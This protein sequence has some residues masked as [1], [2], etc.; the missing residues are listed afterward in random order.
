[1]VN[2]DTTTTERPLRR[3]TPRMMATVAS[4]RARYKYEFEDGL[5]RRSGGSFPWP[6]RLKDLLREVFWARD[7]AMAEWGDSDSWDALLSAV[8]EEWA[9]LV[10]DRAPANIDR[11][12][13]DTSITSTALEARAIANH[14]Q[15]VHHGGFS[16]PQIWRDKHGPVVRRMVEFKPPIP[17]DRD[18]SYRVRS[19][20]SLAITLD[21]VVS[22]HGVPWLVVRHFTSDRDRES[23]LADLKQRMD[24][25]GHAWGAA[26]AIGCGVA[27]ILFDVI[28]TKPPSRPGTVQCRHCKG[29]GESVDPVTTAKAEC[30]QCAGTGVGGLSKQACDTTTE[31][32]KDTLMRYPHLLT[33]E[34]AA[35]HRDAVLRLRERGETFAYR[36]LVKVPREALVEW[37]FDTYATIKEL[38]A[39]RRHGR[40]PRN[41]AA[42]L[43]RAG[44]CPY[45][46]PCSAVGQERDTFLFDKVDEAFPGEHREPS[47]AALGLERYRHERSRRRAA[48]A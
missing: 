23:V 27:G 35:I 26:E 14:Y 48:E 36:A 18:G 24:W 40:W 8:L 42:C 34:H 31:V 21:K 45:R 39:A 13:L 47:A 43:G 10:R 30:A 7:E 29:S 19:R 6:P 12:R 17:L 44:A 38:D 3:L 1:M 33:D 2:A 20:Y 41:T 11:A 4:C 46:A 22:I 9:K 37:M 25:R 28:R 5:R 15:N 16:D 32:W